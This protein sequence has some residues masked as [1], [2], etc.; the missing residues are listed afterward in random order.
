M[1]G[2][3][4]LLTACSRLASSLV[5]DCD[6]SK[7]MVVQLLEAVEEEKE[8]ADV[9][10]RAAEGERERCSQLQQDTA[11][12]SGQGQQW[13][14]EKDSKIVELTEGLE[15]RDRDAQAAYALVSELTLEVERMQEELENAV[16]ERE[17]WRGEA[18]VRRALTV[19]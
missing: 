10:E 14:E 4:G 5:L 17:R 11:D 8:R 9:A 1:E 16:E 13:L 3:P 12:A 15:V 2:I 18:Q 19:A 7:G 6:N